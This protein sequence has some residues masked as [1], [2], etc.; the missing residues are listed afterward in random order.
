MEDFPQWG[1][2]VRREYPPL[3]GETQADVAIV[4]GGLTGVS[5]AA[6]LSALGVKVVLLEARR[7]GMGATWCCTGKV[8]AQ[9]SGVYQ[10]IAQQAGLAAAANYAWLLRES[11]LGVKELCGR[12]GVPVQEQSMYVF[13]ETMDDLPALHALGRLEARLGLPVHQ[14]MD[15]GGCPFPV[16]LSLA[17]ERQLLLSPLAYLLA[18]AEFAR[19][20]GCCI[21]EHTPVRGVNGRRLT[22]GQGSVQAEKIILATGCPGGCT[23]LPLLAGMQQQ[24]WQTVTLM[25]QP[26]LLN[27]H[28][29]VQPDEMSLRPILGGALISW[30]MGRVGSC[31]QNRSLLLQRTLG[32]LLPDMR[33][34]ERSIRQEV[35]SSDGLPLIGPMHPGQSH[36]LMATGYNGWGI[37]GSYLAAKVLAGYIVGRP[38][39]HARLFRPDRPMP[40]GR[41]GLRMAT[42]YLEGISRRR[43]PVCPHMGG[44]LRYDAE[45]RCWVCPCHGSTFTTMGEM[46]NAPAMADAEVSAKQ[47]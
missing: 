32:A 6:M 16:E 45:N 4:G 13:A 15:A 20:Q 3:R 9:V 40:R 39:P 14:A 1:Q 28:L 30:N 11:V 19:E 36:L 22:T 31:Q 37:T 46:L 17:M 34:T 21:Y 35:C 44:K 10:T 18:L 5:C 23:A 33:V 29:S 42:A 12:L 8:T 24:A 25:G 27:C 26:P 2:G 41:E 47:R 38:M 43:A 7:L